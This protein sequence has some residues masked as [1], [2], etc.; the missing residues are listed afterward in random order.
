MIEP[1]Y[2]LTLL[3]ATEAEVTELTEGTSLKPMHL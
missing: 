2:Q 3:L 1:L